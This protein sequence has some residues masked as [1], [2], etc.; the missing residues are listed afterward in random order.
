[1]AGDLLTDGLIPPSGLFR[2]THNMAMIQPSFP[3]SKWNIGEISILK[4]HISYVNT[5]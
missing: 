3:S 5:P 4:F 2:V 1:M